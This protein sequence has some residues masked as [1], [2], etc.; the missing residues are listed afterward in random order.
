[1]T[2]VAFEE[3]KDPFDGVATGARGVTGK[4]GKI[5]MISLLILAAWAFLIP[6]S[7]A[8]VATGQLVSSAR[9]HKLANVSGGRVTMISAREGD[10]VKKGDLIVSLDPATDQA[11]LSALQSR[12]AVLVALKQRLDAE[13]QTPSQ[14]GSSLVIPANLDMRGSVAI[15]GDPNLGA[16][17]EALQEALRAEQL[18]ELNKGRQA[19]AAQLRGIENRA[20]GQRRRVDSLSAQLADSE[21]RVK[22]LSEQFANAQTLSRQGHLPKARVWELEASLLDAESRLSGVRA[23]LAGAQSAVREA[24]AEQVRVQMADSAET[25]EQL[26]EVIAEL[27]KIK[28]EL[29]AAE[30]AR[31]QTS[32]RAPVEGFVLF[33]EVV[34]EGSVF[35]AGQTIVE[36]VPAGEP[37]E[38]LARVPLKDIGNVAIGQEAEVMVTALNSRIYDKIPAKVTFVAA[39]A[40][41]DEATDER[42]YEVRALLDA[43]TI[44]EQKIPLR[45]GMAGDVFI[46]GQSRT[47]AKYMLQPFFDGFSRA[48]REPF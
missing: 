14:S 12:Y 3:E 24:E 11:Q 17:G 35:R 4:A 40:T 32:L 15:D 43:K 25:S 46:V 36:V 22:L 34:T 16:E 19:I 38:T 21:Q 31:T 30:I 5:V 8:V 45:P 33:P 2:Q 10:L 42:Y 39:D 28:D 29:K 23:E 18:R 6:L 20:E 47:F 27:D 48:F 41:R 26:T 13:K 9:N 37:L 44:E 1:M 7:S